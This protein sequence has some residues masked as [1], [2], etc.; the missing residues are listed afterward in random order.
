MTLIG[1][2]L[3]R[4][5]KEKVSLD[6]QACE[7]VR[8]FVQSKSIPDDVRFNICRELISLDNVR[9]SP[10]GAEIGKIANEVMHG[11]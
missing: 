3:V 6:T 8:S 4:A 2:R 7:R 10:L 5:L 1:D 9:K 11:T